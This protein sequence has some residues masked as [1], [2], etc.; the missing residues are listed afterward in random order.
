[1]LYS[2]CSYSG[3]Y[4]EDGNTIRYDNLRVLVIVKQ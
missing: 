4:P 1:M 3:Q 2:A